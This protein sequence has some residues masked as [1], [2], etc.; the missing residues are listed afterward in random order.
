[1]SITKT[2]A[3]SYELKGI[4]D[5]IPKLWSVA[6]VS[7]YKDAESRIKHWGPKRQLF[8]ISQLNRFSMHDVYSPLKILSVF[9][10]GDFVNLHLNEIEDMFLLVLHHTLFNLDG[11]VIVDL[12]VALRIFT[13]SLII[14]KRVK[15]V[16]LGVESYQKKFNITKPQKRL[17]RVD[18]LYKLSGGTLKSVRDILH[19]RLRN[20]RL[21]YNKDMSRRKWLTTDQRIVHTE[22]GDDITI[23]TRRRQDPNGDGVRD[24]KTASEHG[25]LKEDLE[26][27]M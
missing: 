2:K 27:S 26:P 20:F 21:G 6:K 17:M 5:M 7:Y 16:Q 14:K 1:M 18:E 15:N 19:P 8:Y 23:I 25:R 12:A 3:A 9:K 13:R 24:L 4:E 22:R 10:E 11:D